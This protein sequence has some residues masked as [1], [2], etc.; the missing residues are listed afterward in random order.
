VKP[1]AGIAPGPNNRSWGIEAGVR[2]PF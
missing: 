2:V 1:G